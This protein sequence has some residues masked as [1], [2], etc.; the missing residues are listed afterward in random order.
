MLF[1][2]HAA[3]AV[4]PLT[5]LGP[6]ALDLSLPLSQ[7]VRDALWARD[8]AL[9]ADLLAGLDTKS[10][11]PGDQADLAFVR[12]WELQR[13]GRAA[14][15]VPLLEAVRAAEGPP[16]TYVDL[17]VGELLVEAGRPVD[18]LPL[19]ERI[20]PTDPIS[21]RARL[22]LANAYDKAER[23][24]DARRV[25]EQIAG[26]P[27]PSPGAEKALWALAQRNGQGN[28]ATPGLVHTIYRYYP[29]SGE[30]KAAQAWLGTPTVEDLGWRGDLLQERSLFE[31]A[32]TLLATQLESVAADDCRYRYAYG[33]AQHKRNNLSSA[34]AVLEPL[35]K[36]CKG[37]D[38]DRG[39]KALY[40]AGKSLER[41]KEWGA[42][43]RA[44]LAIPA[45][46][47]SHS[48][49]DDGYALGGIALQESGDLQG[50]RTVWAKGYDA[51]KTGDLAPEVAWRLAWGAWLSG[52]T[53][54]A[55]RWADRASED[56]KLEAMPTDVLASRYW[57]G[58]WRI[59]Q[60]RTDASARSTN[61][62]EVERGKALLTAVASAAPW[63]YY[64]LQA[65]ARLRLLDPAAADALTRPAFDGDDR[66][67]QVR[68]SFHQ[69]PAVQAGL[70]L[71]RLGLGRDA[72]AEL[73][74]LGDNTLTGA[75]MAVVT[76][77][78]A[79]SGD[80]LGS[81]D[82]LRSY[83]K[84]HPPDSLGPN[85][86]KVMRVAYP[87]TWWAE[88]QT[89]TKAYSWDGRLFHALVREESN[90][91]PKIKSH[92]GACGLSQLMPATASSTAKR[93]GL[94]YS[95]SKIWDPAT[96]LRIGGAYLDFLVG[97][98]HGNYALALAGYN[99]GEGN[100]DRWLAENLPDPPTDALA[101]SVDFRETRHYIKRVLSS[102]QTYSLLYGQGPVYRDISAWT[103]D[104]VP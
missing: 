62:T 103:L 24:A 40:V 30:D 23:T 83:L 35:G 9:A 14:E 3:L 67:W 50:A 75:E 91:N 2:L 28:P 61:T 8:H 7:G 44:Y 84:T 48:M 39:A 21:A 6:T 4:E 71:Y 88:V 102:Y 37:K 97:R 77:I 87:E 68:D 47:P 60:S 1:L 29:G 73:D 51:Y 10:W 19:L 59:W 22:A 74:P 78:Q 92:A 15:A 104:A 52:D 99:A 31:T 101:E 72:L 66:P 36:A 34:V 25:L 55:I 86:W 94:S 69:S 27:H 63:H 41:K 80:F 18:A 58:R 98:Y 12:A 76:L 56:L 64:G 96:N 65:A 16:P 49:A 89:A 11:P 81:H 45:L 82:R 17:V 32:A 57:A 53:A 46:Y 79:R 42:A 54:E 13:A 70:R 43:A 90:F 26:G 33:R 5:S 38:D 85:T 100:A 95:S 93:I 20:S